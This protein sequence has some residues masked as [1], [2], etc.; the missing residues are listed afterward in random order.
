[1]LYSNTSIAI[2]PTQRSYSRRK[3]QVECANDEYKEAF[4][5]NGPRRDT[6]T[7]DVIC[8]TPF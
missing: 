3:K 7:P 2:C 8:F 4:T 1:M 5:C 6:A